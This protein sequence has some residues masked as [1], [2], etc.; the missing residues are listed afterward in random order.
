ML[1]EVGLILIIVAVVL[2]VI[3]LTLRRRSPRAAERRSRGRRTVATEG[4]DISR[5]RPRVAEVHVYGPEARV[6]FDVPLPQGDDEVLADLLTAEAVEVVREK[7]HTLP[8]SQ[9]TEVVALA[10]REGTAQVVGRS[11]L[12]APGELPPPITVPSVLH[13]SHIGFDPLAGQFDADLPEQVPSAVGRPSEDRLRPIGSEL[14]L[15]RAVE[16]GLRAQGIDPE[17]M[18]AIDLVVGTLGLF[19]YQISPGARPGTFRAVKGGAT[20]YIRHDPY[21]EGGYPEVGEETIG[22]FLVDFLSSGA[23]R[24]MLVSEKFA[25]FGAYQKERREPR[26]RFVTRE[27]LQKFVD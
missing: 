21:E 13:L 16:V 24:G 27:R 3:G 10:G 8:M 20:T 17:A 6:T 23:E 4:L 22:S 7:R 11:K 14:R 9:V 2:F 5:P 15:P 18:T 1:V 26:I 25:P 19:G 12:D